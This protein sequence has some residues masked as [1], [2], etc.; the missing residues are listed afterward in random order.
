MGRGCADCEVA[1]SRAE[2]GSEEIGD[3]VEEGVSLA[4][5]DG[6]GEVVVVGRTM[7]DAGVVDPEKALMR[8]SLGVCTVLLEAT[9]GSRVTHSVTVAIQA[10]VLA[11]R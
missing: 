11:A 1:W 7:G 9:E 5:S 10:V 8:T 3:G 2:V 4:V 6:A